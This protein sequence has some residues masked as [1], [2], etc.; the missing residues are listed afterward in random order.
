MPQSCWISERVEWRTNKYKSQQIIWGSKGLL[1]LERAYALPPDF[2]STLTIETQ[3]GITQQTM[4]A[5]NH[6]EEEMR[7]FVDNYAT[8]AEA[9]REEFLNQTRVL[10]RVKEY[11]VNEE[12]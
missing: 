8:H 7:Y 6:F 5:C 12:N 4:P 10:M 11:V 1:S 3:E 2:Q 9:W